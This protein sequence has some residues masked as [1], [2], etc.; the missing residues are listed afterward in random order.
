MAIMVPSI[1]NN[2]V[3]ASREGEIFNSLKR[4]PN[5][6][7]VFHSLRIIKIKNNEWI[8]NEIDFVVFNK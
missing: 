7:Y 5:D 3:P 6:Y 8:E 4:L 1:P 2:F